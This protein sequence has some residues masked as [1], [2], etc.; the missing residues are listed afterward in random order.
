MLAKAFSVLQSLFVGSLGLGAAL[1]PLLVSWLGIRGALLASG[2]VLPLLVARA[3][4]S[5]RSGSTAPGCIADDAVDLLRSVS[6]FAPLELRDASSG[7]PAPLVAVDV[8]A[9]PDDRR[10]R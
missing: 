1:A 10:R 5:P 6:I 4:G 9:G 2:V 8:E 3:L 7:S